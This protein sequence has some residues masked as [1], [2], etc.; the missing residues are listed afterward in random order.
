MNYEP[1]TWQSGDVITSEKL[2][3]IENALASLAAA[4]TP[5]ETNAVLS[6]DQTTGKQVITIDKTAEEL[7]E[8]IEAGK[9]IEAMFTMPGPADQPIAIRKIVNVS[10][11]LIGGTLYEFTMVEVDEDDG[12]IG[13]IASNVLAEDTVVFTEV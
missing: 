6:V 5:L 7:F 9:A 1:N 13:F 11:M 8:A 4:Q 12:V 3:R 10:G 2:N